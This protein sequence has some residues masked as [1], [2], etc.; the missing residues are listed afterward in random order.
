MAV[1][2]SGGIINFH[3]VVDV[4]DG[5]ADRWCSHHRNGATLAA[6]LP[7]GHPFDCYVRR[8]DGERV[9]DP[10]IYAPDPGDSVILREVPGAAAG[11]FAIVAIILTAGSYLVQRLTAPK[12]PGSDFGS[13]DGPVQSF[14]GIQTISAGGVPLPLVYGEVRTGGNIVDSFESAKN[15]SDFVLPV[16]PTIL[17]NDPF[18]ATSEFIRKTVNIGTRRLARSVSVLNTR[19]V[20]CAGPVESIHSIEIDE[21]SVDDFAGLVVEARGGSQHQGSIVDFN[22]VVKTRTLVLAVPQATPVEFTT[23]VEVDQ[24]EPVLRFA[25][26]LYKIK[27]DGFKF[28]RAVE[29]TVEYRLESATSWILAGTFIVDDF[30]VNALE[31]RIRIGPL[32]RAKYDVKITRVTVDETDSKK[33]SAFQLFFVN[34]ITFQ[35]RNHP[36]VAQLAFSQ[37]PGELVSPIHPTNYTAVVKG[38]NDIRVYTSDTEFTTGWTDNPAWCC[39]HFLTSKLNGMGI[40]F[41]WEDINIPSFLLWAKHADGLVEDGRGALEKRATFNK[42]YDTRTNAFQILQ[43]FATGSGVSI[44][45]KGAQFRVVVDEARPRVQIFSEANV[46]SGQINRAYFPKSELP[47]RIHVQFRN[48]ENNWEL[49]TV[50]EEDPDIALGLFQSAK[51]F[52]MLHITR[53]GHAAREAMRVVRTNTLITQGVEFTAGLQA[54]SLSVGDRIGISS[55]GVGIGL[56]SGQITHVESDNM[57]MHLDDEI[58][59]EAGKT[60]AISVQHVYDGIIDTVLLVHGGDG[61]TTNIAQSVDRPWRRDL[62]AGDK[63]A[64]G[65]ADSQVRDYRV[66]AVELSGFGKKFRVKI[67]AGLYDERAF[68]LTPVSN[69][70][71]TANE[72][73]HRD[74]VPGSVR[75]LQAVYSRAEPS[76][77]VGRRSQRTIE[78]DWNPPESFSIDHYEVLYRESVNTGT[79]TGGREIEAAWQIAGTTRGRRFEISQN[80]DV[81]TAYEIVVLAVSPGGQRIDVDVAPVR[82]VETF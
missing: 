24:I 2:M 32:D 72:L 33:F 22:R 73:P 68:D 35:E 66:D 63:Y 6:Y 75:N 7:K 36:G 16:D 50:M 77:R 17:A 9:V 54:A 13:P 76:S 81:D 56:G 11:V 31:Y 28:N 30:A 71:V 43:D 74:S 1:S 41:S 25:T 78:V 39:G 12:I 47:T 62:Q 19:L 44:I 42:I 34:E 18:A 55:V 59:F 4:F 52:R 79:P 3:R 20:L 58:T 70:F 8:V 40:V 64:V 26:G 57:T 67:R 27:D 60:Y 82:R 46:I 51:T 45:Y 53:P 65:E 37:L 29:I 5:K 38:F 23:T 14:G 48:L 49:D 80:I 21:R 61:V 69:P 10:D 15:D